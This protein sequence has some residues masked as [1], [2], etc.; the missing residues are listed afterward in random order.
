M[1][2]IPGVLMRRDPIADVAPLV[3]DIPRSGT[4]YPY[5]FQP[6][7][8]FE[9]VHR[10]ISM[11]VDQ[12]YEGVT[13]AGATWLYALFPNA[14]IDANRHEADIDPEQLDAP[15]PGVLE[16]TEKSR[17][18]IGLIHSAAGRDRIP[19]YDRKLAVGDVRNRIDSYYWPYHH[20]LGRLLEEH[21]ARRGVAYHV[22]CHSMAAIGGASTL[23]AGSPR[24]DFDIGD[25]HGASCEPAFA[26]A[27]DSDAA[28]IWLS[29]HQQF[30]LRGRGV[31]A[32]AQCA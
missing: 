10:S 30:P 23:D 27:R 29:G 13:A 2:T 15:W 19:L 11:Y 6:S 7:A 21:R 22:S 28:R 17:L 25:R 9:A 4:W 16:P 26:R 1:L 32:Q 31:G 8:S 5:D 18:G 3:F 14:Y 24:S 20:E 12:L